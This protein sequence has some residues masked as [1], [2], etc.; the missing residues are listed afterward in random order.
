[1]DDILTLSRRARDFLWPTRAVCLGCGDLT[2]HEDGE[3]L[4]EKCLEKLRFGFHAINPGRLAPGGL[5]GAYFAAYYE[6]PVA[7]VV[8]AVKF[9]GV[10]RAIPFLAEGLVPAVNAL[11][12]RGFDA[13]APVPLHPRRKRE[14]GF[15]QALELARVLS[16]RCG[17]PVFEG[18]RRVRYT[19]RQAKMSIG[20]RGDNVRGAF[21]CREDLRGQ[22]L[23]LVDDVYTT[24]AT[25]RACAEALWAAGAGDVQGVTVAGSRYFRRHGEL[26]FRKRL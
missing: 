11:K 6:A 18:L 3:W 8:R 9:G 26:L 23:L 13:L 7:G 25:L 14:R 17:L 15:D 16:E 4:C 2:G 1:M 22:R 5:T 24:G 12:A 21:D 19:R 10:R 20:A